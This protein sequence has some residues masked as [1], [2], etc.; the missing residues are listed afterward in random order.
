MNNERQETKYL[1]FELRIDPGQEREY[2]ISVIKS[3][4]GEACETMRFPYRE[5]IICCAP[6]NLVCF[7][8]T[9]L[10]CAWFC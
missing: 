10:P 9:T 2:P 1:D 7:W 3:P 8:L 5:N 6:P 4:A